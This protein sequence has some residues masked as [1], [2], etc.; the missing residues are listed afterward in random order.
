MTTDNEKTKRGLRYTRVVVKVGTNL[1]TGGTGK[2]DLERMASLVTQLAR[3]RNSGVGVVLVSS[4]AVAAGRHTLS[5]AGTHSTTLK[6]VLASIGQSRLMQSYEQLF[7]WQNV[8]VAQI[9]LTRADISDRLAYL[10]VRNT[11]NAL[12]DLGVLPIVNENDAVAVEELSSSIIGDNDNLS[13]M[14]ATLLDADLLVILSDVDGFY[15][16]DP[17]KDS[18]ARLIPRVDKIDDLVESMASTT[19]SKNA[20]GGMITKIEGAKLATVAGVDVIITD[21]RK[22]N[23][24]DDIMS[25]KQV[26]TLFK[27]QGTRLESRK[28]WFMSGL[29]NKGTIVVDDGAA[30]AIGA[31]NKSLL[32]AG[33]KDVRGDFARGDIVSIVSVA[34]KKLAAGI[35]N[36]SAAELKTIKGAKSADIA[37]LLG[38]EYGD[39][40]V[41]RN[42]MV[43]L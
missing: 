14:V 7:G 40:A 21:G 16:A 23:V 30:K 36:Y 4:G 18:S 31:Q 15:T 6:Q 11:F 10:N 34:G 8:I 41:H 43:A 28:R 33:V 5:I 19:L 3:L 2:L 1:L 37:T 42:N 25:G 35:S 17:R 13:A 12:L 9:L 38:H 26:G 39:E 27:A 24:L 20:V 32:P 22:P 29:S